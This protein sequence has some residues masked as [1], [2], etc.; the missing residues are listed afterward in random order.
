MTS[1]GVARIVNDVHVLAAAG[2]RRLAAFGFLSLGLTTPS[3]RAGADV[4]TR[5]DTSE[6]PVVRVVGQRGEINIRTWD[7][8]IV[9]I[10]SHSP[11]E[12]IE[13]QYGVMRFGADPRSIPIVAQIALR[14]D[15]PLVLPPE[16]FVVAN[17]T[18]GAH[19]NVLVRTH[20]ATTTVTIPA[21]TSLLIVTSTA[22]S[23]NV[24]GYHGSFVVSSR[25]ANIALHAMGGAGFAQT[26]FGR[27]EISDSTLDRIRARTGVRA[28]RF[29]RCNVR[30]VEASSV[31]GNVVYDAG[32]FAPGL[33]RFATQSGIVAIGVASGGVAIGAHSPNG[34]VFSAF[35][36]GASVAGSASDATATIN[37]G[38][39]LVT[40]TTERG[41][42]YLYDGALRAKR[43]LSA[44]WS[45]PLRV[46]APAPS[47]SED[48]MTASPQPRA[49]LRAPVR[50]PREN[51]SLPPRPAPARAAPNK[52]GSP[53]TSIERGAV[54]DR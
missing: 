47:P 9:Q 22:G 54:L 26:I 32:T 45:R 21:T 39:P 30:Q 40:V 25:G 3:A 6:A 10:E 37:G 28:L 36:R 23:I 48:T 38:G 41:S 52:P 18:P 49:R 46:F 2:M 42:V 1:G 16:E 51:E 50:P 14:P 12:T 15:G 31:S 33:A 4:L 43:N 44:D 11:D 34:R 27:L 19:D 7:R 8:N 17:V 53:F 13:E 29:D 5:H 24:D 20:F 35:A